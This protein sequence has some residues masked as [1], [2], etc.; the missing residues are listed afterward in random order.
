MTH[1]LESLTKRTDCVAPLGVWILLFVAT[2]IVRWM[3]VG[4]L[5]FLAY[6]KAFASKQDDAK[7]MEITDRTRA[8]GGKLRWPEYL[9]EIDSKTEHDFIFI[10]VSI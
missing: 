9:L 10:L 2:E 4:V 3:Y 8:K 7:E 6:C 5:R 1:A